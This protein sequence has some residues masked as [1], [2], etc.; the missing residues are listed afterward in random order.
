[1]DKNNNLT[2]CKISIITVC[3]N[4]AAELEETILSVINQTFQDYEYI[5][6]DGGSK[7]GTLD[8]INKYK[9][10]ITF[11]ISE[12]D[13]GIYD[14]MNKG[15][16]YASGEWINFMNAGDIFTNNNVLTQI[17][18]YTYQKD[19]KF[20]YS[21]NFYRQKNGKLLLS[22]NSHEKLC[23]LHQSSIY[24]KDLH[25]KHGMYIVTSQII[26]SDF[27]FFCRIEEQCF[28]KIDTI[29]SINTMD[30]VSSQ[31]WCRTQY[32]CALV[33]FRKINMKTLFIKYT[34]FRLKLLFPFLYNLINLFRKK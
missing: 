27:L 12:P 20:L 21:D 22:S 33:V 13:K 15:L 4:A 25:K 16:N 30:G 10:K 7:D 1:M 31:A 23:L 28:K 17:F 2:R 26:I 3:Y 32:L 14:A 29:I 5:I 9:D 24:K 19:I 6:I 11:W 18:S 8:I 34:A